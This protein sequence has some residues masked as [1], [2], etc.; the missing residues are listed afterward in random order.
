[1]EHMKDD[2][3]QKK[4]LGARDNNQVDWRATLRN[5]LQWTPRHLPEQFADTVKVIIP[6][7]KATR[8]LSHSEYSMWDINSRTGCGMKLYRFGDEGY[9]EG[10]EDHDPYLIID[11]HH[12]SVNTAIDEILSL[13]RKVTIISRTRDTEEVLWD[14]KVDGEDLSLPAPSVVVS[15]RRVPS[16]REPYNVNIRAHEFPKPEEWTRKTFI[17]YVDAL[18][19]SRMPSDLASQLYPEHGR[20]QQAVIQQLVAIFNDE[21]AAPFVSNAAFKM[22]LHYMTRGG[23]TWRPEMLSLFNYA[24]RGRMLHLDVEVFNI[25]AEAAVKTR[26]LHRFNWVLYLMVT[27]GYQPNLRTWILALR[28]FEAEEVKRY[29][30]QAMNDRGLFNAH[31]APRMVAGEMAPHDAYRAVQLNWDVPTFLAKQDELYGG[32]ER[33]WVSIDVLNKVIHVFGSYSKFAEIGELL[34]LIFTD[35]N[36]VAHPDQVTVNT[37]LAHCKAQKKLDLAVEFVQLF[38]RYSAS[39]GEPLLELEPLACE[40]LFEM[41]HWAKKPH[42][43]STVW[44]YAH[45]INATSY[46]VRR[47]GIELMAMDEAELKK[48]KLVRRLE[49]GDEERVPFIRNLLLGEFIQ[50]NGGEEVWGEVMAG[51]AKGEQ[52]RKREMEEMFA[53]EREEEMRA[54]EREGETPTSLGDWFKSQL[55]EDDS[56]ST[57]TPSSESSKLPSSRPSNLSQPTQA[58]EPQESEEPPTRWGHFYSSFRRWSFTTQF[59]QLEPAVPI[60]SLLQEALDRDRELHLALR[61]PELGSD[62]KK[63]MTPIEIPTRPRTEPA[64]GQVD[65]LFKYTKP[66]PQPLERRSAKREGSRKKDKRKTHEADA[67]KIVEVQ[68]SIRRRALDKWFSEATAAAEGTT[69]VV[70]DETKS[71]TSKSKKKSKKSK[72]KAAAA[73]AV[74]AAASSSSSSSSKSNKPKAT[75]TTTT[76][77]ASTPQIPTPTQASAE[78]AQKTLP[79]PPI[80][81]QTQTEDTGVDPP[82]SSAADLSAYLEEI[83]KREKS[84]KSEERVKW[85]DLADL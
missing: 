32:G 76:P 12:H 74:E 68:E 34:D 79:P 59:L 65:E 73:A 56:N 50:A 7:D 63:L 30:L 40:M 39:H 71:A 80:P 10:T 5:L 84:E 62:I 82:L 36:L 41:A 61:N 4:V 38:E 1:M 64:I 78:E 21:A 20:H 53:A 48:E 69:T 46:D 57:I 16:S 70:A 75:P 43:L 11:G 72:K 8:L 19:K 60:G 14:G 85:Q 27:S 54:A 83:S 13:T 24:H 31:G 29:V 77:I 45:L 17:E 42:V 55:E 67:A 51:L 58:N 25:L 26:S 9:E 23:E 3:R 2:A 33:N 35:E 18:V 15:A 28:M 37:I 49:M 47:R 81:T 44:R 22:A 52:E 6:R 66:K